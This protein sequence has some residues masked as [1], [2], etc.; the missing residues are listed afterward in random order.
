MGPGFPFPGGFDFSQLMRMLQSQGPVNFD[1]ARQVSGVIAT[2]DP[3]TGQ[4]GTEP[5]LERDAATTFESLVRAAQSAVGDTTGIAAVLA[6]PNQT[7]NRQY[8]SSTTLDRLA[9]VLEALAGALG[10]APTPD[11]DNPPEGEQAGEDAMFGFLM[12][13]LL[14]VLLGVWSGWMIGQLSHHALGQFALPLPLEGPPELLFVAR[15]V[16]EFASA[17][18]LPADELRYALV[19]RETVHA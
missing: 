9:P 16:D 4:P 14:P 15:N 8:W 13:S 19:L 5:A 3:D 2:S 7:V 18:E 1:V 12:Q 11:P 10:R 17:W 6:V